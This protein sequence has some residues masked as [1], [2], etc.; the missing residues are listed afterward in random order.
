MHRTILLDQVA[1]LV[2]RRPNTTTTTITTTTATAPKK[3]LTIK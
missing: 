1:I 3:F 2:A